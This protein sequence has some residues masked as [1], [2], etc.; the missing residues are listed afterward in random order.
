MQ[1]SFDCASECSVQD[2]CLK[3]A[4]WEA[5]TKSRRLTKGC[6]HVAFTVM[7][8]NETTYLPLI[9]RPSGSDNDKNCLIA[10]VSSESPLVS[11]LDDNYNALSTGEKF[12]KSTKASLWTVVAVDTSDFK[13]N[14]RKES[15]LPKLSVKKFFDKSVEKAI[16]QDHKLR[17]LHEPFFY[18]QFAEAGVDN[19]SYSRSVHG[20]SRNTNVEPADPMMVVIQNPHAS[21]MKA[22]FNAIEEAYN[23]KKPTVTHNM[24]LL[25]AQMDYYTTISG[26][27]SNS[28]DP[29]FVIHD[30][31]SIDA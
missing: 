5:A 28:F 31:R 8:Y 12:Y 29:S 30:L 2:A 1:V 25:K 22:E 19:I 4:W 26:D 17:L 9:Q 14:N 21:T 27:L 13:N 6:K 3:S 7:I 15:R 23:G 10:F 18:L 24:T 20:T 16:Y 11:G